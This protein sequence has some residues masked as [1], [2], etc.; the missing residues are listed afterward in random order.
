MSHG[1]SKK[2]IMQY[3]EAVRAGRELQN[4]IQPGDVILVK[5]SQGMRM[6]KIVMDLMAKP[7]L[8]DTLLVRQSRQ[9]QKKI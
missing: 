8:S 4:F 1:L 5:G 6:E 7:D 3:D 2:V 9:W